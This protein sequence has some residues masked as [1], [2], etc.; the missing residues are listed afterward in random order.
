MSSGV[1]VQAL[2]LSEGGKCFVDCWPG[3]AVLSTCSSK[4]SAEA[5]LEAMFVLLLYAL[6]WYVLYG[7]TSFQC[8]G[9]V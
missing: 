3:N 5:R 9:F 8:F 4:S 1:H 6:M 2:G 7:L